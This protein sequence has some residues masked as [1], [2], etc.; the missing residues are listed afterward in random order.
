MTT[1]FSVSNGSVGEF[2]CNIAQLT[3]PKNSLRGILLPSPRM[4]HLGAQIHI[5]VKAKVGHNNPIFH[6]ETGC[7]CIRWCKFYWNP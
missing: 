2:H 4:V 5:S 1:D 7:L 3:S 6:Q